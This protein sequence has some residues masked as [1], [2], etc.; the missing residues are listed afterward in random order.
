MKATTCDIRESIKFVP[1]IDGTVTK[2]KRKKKSKK[3]QKAQRERI[4]ETR[5]SLLSPN[6]RGNKTRTLH[7]LQSMPLPS[8]ISTSIFFFLSLFS[9]LPQVESMSG[10]CRW[11]DRNWLESL[12]QRSWAMLM[13]RPRRIIIKCGRS[14]IWWWWLSAADS[15]VSA[16]LMVKSREKTGAAWKFSRRNNVERF[17]NRRA[18]CLDAE[19]LIGSEPAFRKKTWPVFYP[20]LFPPTPNIFAALHDSVGGR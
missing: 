7:F 9:P 19:A 17:Y 14:E 20:S 12:F 16:N 2:T 4:E 11:R 5:K 13:H 10:R 3:E 8:S 1:S 18:V 6:R 15:T